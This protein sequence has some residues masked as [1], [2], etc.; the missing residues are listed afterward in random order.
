MNR[1]TDKYF[2][3]ERILNLNKKFQKVFTT[4]LLLH[5]FNTILFSQNQK[6]EFRKDIFIEN[7]KISIVNKEVDY[8]TG[9]ITV[10]DKLT[11][12]DV[13]IADNIYTTYNSDTL[14]D[15]NNDGSKEL[16]ID[17]ATGATMYDYNM[18]LIFDFKKVSEPFK[19]RNAE[20]I[21]GNNEQPKILSNVRLSPSAL[22]AGYSYILKYEN[23]E[24]V[25]D[26]DF[27]NSKALKDIAPVESDDLYLINE[28]KKEFNECSSDSDFK[29]YFEAKIIQQKFIGKEKNGWK[30][31]DKYY[32]C[33]NK[34]VIKKELKKSVDENYLEMN[35][36]ENFI[37][38]K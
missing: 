37:F 26:K 19:V 2:Q 3:L 31:F 27:T 33:K 15:L 9:G 4:I 23:S 1:I 16:I 10:S 29:I 35:N 30:F 5:S 14:I 28:Y 17:L 36:P 11:N 13:F 38:K 32:R 7:Y 24:F 8:F 25:L 18:F 6:G 20:L 21:T 34:N 22:G 12:K